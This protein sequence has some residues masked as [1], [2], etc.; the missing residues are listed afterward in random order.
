MVS[1]RHGHVCL[2]LLWQDHESV[3]HGDA[4]GCPLYLSVAHTVPD[5]RLRV[6]GL[7]WHRCYLKGQRRDRKGTITNFTSCLLLT[8]TNPLQWISCIAFI[9]FHISVLVHMICLNGDF[10]AN[11]VSPVSIQVCPLAEPMPGWHTLTDGGQRGFYFSRRI[12]IVSA[13]ARLSCLLSCD[14]LQTP[15]LLTLNKLI[16][17]VHS[18][19]QR[20]WLGWRLW[21]HL[22][23]SWSP[24]ISMN[25]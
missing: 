10:Y 18:W 12:C 16:P 3:G 9:I 13:A 15:T 14:L 4:E 8:S 17:H 22:L 2:Q 20:S 1:L 25:I 6:L 21:L 19:T 7:H 11:R 5:G 23:S 24:C